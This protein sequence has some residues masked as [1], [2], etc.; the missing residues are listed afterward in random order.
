MIYFTSDTLR[1]SFFLSEQ[2]RAT[3]HNEHAIKVLISLPAPVHDAP[4]R[5]V[6][7]KIGK[8]DGYNRSGLGRNDGR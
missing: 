4:C 7:K 2:K 3:L 6:S 8:R 1:N 5:L